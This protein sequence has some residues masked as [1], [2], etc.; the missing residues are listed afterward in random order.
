VEVVVGAVEVH[1]RRA[2]DWKRLLAWVL[3]GLPFAA[4]FAFGL[5]VA[6]DRLPHAG[7]LDFSTALD[8]AT[9][10][11]SG[12]TAPVFLGALVIFVVY[13]ALAHA[14]CG[15]TL[16]KRLVRIRVVGPDGRRP[17]LGR[18]AIRAF[19]AGFSLVFLG[20]GVILALFTRSG[21]ALH[22]LLARTWVVEAP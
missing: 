9:A 15:A 18:A 13:H 11:A 21:R 12:I 5:R 16:G 10:E 4:L 14:L 22:D 20:L 7:V 19:L 3:D 8:L 1:L 17:G 2:P 6:L